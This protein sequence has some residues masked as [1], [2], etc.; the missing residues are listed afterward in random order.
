MRCQTPRS[1]P[2]AWTRTSTSSSPISGRSISRSS[3]PSAGPY[4]SLRDRFM[5]RQ[6]RQGSTTALSASPLR[7]A[8]SAAPVSASAE[9]VGHQLERAD[10]LAGEQA[11]RA[12]HVRRA[13]RPARG[14]VEL[15]HEDRV[16]VDR[17]RAAGRR[18][19]VDAERAAGR[20]RV[21]RGGDRL[22]ARRA[23][24]RDVDRLVAVRGR[25]PALGAREP[26]RAAARAPTPPRRRSRGR[27]RCSAA[28]S[29]PRRS[30]AGRR[31]A[32]GRRGAGRAARTPAAR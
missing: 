4:V 15:A 23:D 1:T 19:R 29:R 26:L 14:D 12:P 11:E 20:E 30:R 27:R 9:A 32:R 6:L 2:A 13:G 24:D 18:R 22:V 10:G 3:R 28:R 25:A 7:W 5:D 8:A 17:Q 31:R 16:A 21:G